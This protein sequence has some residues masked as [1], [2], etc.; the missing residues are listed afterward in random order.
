L[1]Q[2]GQHRGDLRREGRRRPAVVAQRLLVPEEAAVPLRLFAVE[3]HVGLDERSRRE[4][5]LR[6]RPQPDRPVD[7]DATGDV[8]NDLALD[9]TGRLRLP[10]AGGTLGHLPDDLRLVVAA[11]AD[12]DAVRVALAARGRF[13]SGRVVHH[14]RGH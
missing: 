8:L 11:D 4:S 9:L 13:P 3:P 6:C 10:I 5:H 12:S 2:L 14:T 7:H 1:D